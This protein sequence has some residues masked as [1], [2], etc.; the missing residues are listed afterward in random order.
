[1]GLHT[2]DHTGNQ[3]YRHVCPFLQCIT[4]SHDP[5]GTSTTSTTPIGICKK[6]KINI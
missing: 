1:M 4:S 3:L 6:S 2:M 5:D